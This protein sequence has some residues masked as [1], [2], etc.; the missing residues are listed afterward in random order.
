MNFTEPRLGHDACDRHGIIYLLCW[1]CQMQGLEMPSIRQKN[2][3]ERSLVMTCIPQL[4]GH[5]QPLGTAGGYEAQG[6]TWGPK[7][8]IDT[9]HSEWPQQVVFM[10]NGSI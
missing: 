6:L 2:R 1:N 4:P 5:G 10:Q 8:W 9:P 7:L 3:T